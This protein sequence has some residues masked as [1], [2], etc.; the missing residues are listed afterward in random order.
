MVKV[1]Y[2]FSNNLKLIELKLLINVFYLGE[3]NLQMD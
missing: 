1:M 2:K 3:N